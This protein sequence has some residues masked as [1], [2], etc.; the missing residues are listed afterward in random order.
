LD[1][2]KG[3]IMAE[4][5]IPFSNNNKYILDNIKAVVAL[6]D[7]FVQFKNDFPKKL[8][9]D[10]FEKI[11]ERLKNFDTTGWHLQYDSIA[12]IALINDKYWNEKAVSGFYYVIYDFK[13]DSLITE[14]QEDGLVTSL[15]YFASSKKAQNE[16]YDKVLSNINSSNKIKKY[17]NPERTESDFDLISQS[18]SDTVNINELSDDNLADK[19]AERFTYFFESTRHV[20]EQTI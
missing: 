15:Y 9:A 13:Y 2:L 11:K 5:N 19:I 16:M 18:L 10:V 4:S 12:Q 6:N 3:E 7:M 20:L 14:N 17:L 8:R 1:Q